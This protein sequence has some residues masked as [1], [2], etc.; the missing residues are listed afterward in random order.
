MYLYH[1]AWCAGLPSLTSSEQALRYHPEEVHV[2]HMV[3]TEQQLKSS[4]LSLT[5]T[6]QFIFQE[7]VPLTTIYKKDRMHFLP[8]EETR[9]TFWG[10]VLLLFSFLW[11]TPALPAALPRA[12][13]KTGRGE[14]WRE[15][16]TQAKHTGKAWVMVHSCWLQHSTTGGGCR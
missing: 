10:F 11:R 6:D 12:N 16:G 4:R 14:G 9:D 8:S 15:G 2:Q 7:D 3:Q 13:R 5:P 1:A